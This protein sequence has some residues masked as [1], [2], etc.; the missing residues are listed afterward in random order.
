VDGDKKL[1][2]AD[3]TYLGSPIPQFYYG[4]T[5]NANYRAFDLSMV[6]QGVG[7][8]TVYNGPV[9]A[10]KVMNNTDN[11]SV[12]VLDRWTPSNHSNTMLEQIA[13]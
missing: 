7:D 2:D 6:L 3:R 12:T 4:M 1:T 5:F 8:Y 11:Q 9:R 13:V 10:L